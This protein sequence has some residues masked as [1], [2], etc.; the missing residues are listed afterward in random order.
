MGLSTLFQGALCGK[1]LSGSARGLQDVPLTNYT[2][3]GLKGRGTLHVK[4]YEVGRMS[5]YQ[6]EFKVRNGGF[7]LGVRLL[8]VVGGS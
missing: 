4:E 7:D 5:I 3:K 6:D 8:W 2:L 1:S